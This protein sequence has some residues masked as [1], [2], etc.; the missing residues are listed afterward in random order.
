MKKITQSKTFWFNLLTGVAA[1]LEAVADVVPP[2]AN[3]YVLGGV[4]V[5]NIG[6]RVI[7]TSGI[8][9]SK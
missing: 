7:T 9:L 8:K 4:A 1:I 5:I 3:P 2:D 6:L